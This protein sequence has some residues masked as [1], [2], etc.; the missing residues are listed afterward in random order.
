[1]D[2]GLGLIDTDPFCIAFFN[3]LFLFY[4]DSLTFDN[5]IVTVRVFRG[6]ISIG[7]KKRALNDQR[8]HENV[9]G[10]DPDGYYDDDDYKDFYYYDG[11]RKREPYLHLRRKRQ[12]TSPPSVSIR[13]A[14]L[15][16]SITFQTDDIDS[17][18]GFRAVFE[19]A[20]GEKRYLPGKKSMVIVMA[21]D[22]YITADITYN[23]MYF[24]LF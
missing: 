15:N 4:S 8:S 22:L 6:P 10:E 13:G 18:G 24:A 23:T 3:S 11:R 7:R 16:A 5:G 21:Q 17:D 2:G 1:M 14:N 9:F 20:T 12:S 19:T